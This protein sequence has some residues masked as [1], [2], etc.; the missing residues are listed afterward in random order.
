LQNLQVEP[1]C[2]VFPSYFTTELN[3]FSGEL[4][5]GDSPEYPVPFA[6]E[7]LNFSTF[8]SEEAFFIYRYLPANE[9]LT[10]SVSSVPVVRHPI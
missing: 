7:K 9:K 3:V 8:S 2:T 10:P 6:Q 4:G 1:L 5:D